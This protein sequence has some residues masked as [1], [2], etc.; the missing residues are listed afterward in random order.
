MVSVRS[1]F[2]HIAWMPSHSTPI[3]RMRRDPLS[4]PLPPVSR[5][6]LCRPDRCAR[7]LLV[8]TFSMFSCKL[9]DDETH[10]FRSVQLATP[11]VPARNQETEQMEEFRRDF[12]RVTGL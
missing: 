2:C 12:L 11:A 4:L 6:R 1:L 8:L 9:W 3:W 10:G 7:F 5:M